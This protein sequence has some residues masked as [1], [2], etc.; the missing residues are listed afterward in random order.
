MAPAG[1]AILIGAGPTTGAGIARI[2]AHPSHGNLA[3]AL[4]ARNPSNLSSLA[5]SLRLS[6]QDATIETI[7]TD[8]QPSSL[9]AA[10]TAIKSHQ[11]FE[12][13]KLKVAIFSIKHSSKKPFLEETHEEFT[14]SLNEY[15]GGTFS[16]AQEV[17][18]MLFEQHGSTALAEGG[19]KK[20]TLIFMGTLG[21]LRTN[22]QFAAYGAGRSS[23]RMLAQ[24]L[25]KEY[26]EK[27]VHVVHAI[28][29]GSIK[30]DDTEDQ[31]RGK[32]MSAE[33][34]GRTYLWLSEQGPDLLTHELDLRPA[35]E[36]F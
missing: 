35:Q 33:S 17:L 9:S 16:F 27:G 8:T 11:S 4:L 15:V 7:P 22:A 13:L 32:T 26:S 19:E 21:A 29:N 10:F 25:A 34:V 3:V 31:R 5:T 28:A 12:G 24:S 18:K 23:V 2:L 6:V 20:G 36:K 1:L 30:D 14:Q